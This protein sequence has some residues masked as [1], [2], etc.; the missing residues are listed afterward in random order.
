MWVESIKRDRVLHVVLSLEIGGAERIVSS[1]VEGG[2]ASGITHGVCCLDQ[3]GPLA[4]A[5]EGTGHDVHLVRRKPGIDLFMPFKLAKL[6]ALGGYTRLHAHGETPWF[7]GVLAVVLTL[8]IKFRCL[9]TIHGYGGGNKAALAHSLLWRLLMF[10]SMR[11]VVVSEDLEHEMKAIY[12]VLGKKVETIRNGISQHTR[13]SPQSRDDWGLRGKCVVGVVSRLAPVKNHLLLLKAAER[14]IGNRMSDLHVMI[15][16]DGP[17]REALEVYAQRPGLKGHVI[18]TGER[19]DALSFYSLFDLF[20]LPSLS[21]GLS[22]ALLE[23]A[24]FGIPLI[25]SSVGGNTEIVSHLET[26]LTFE[27]DNLDDLSRQVELLL[28]TPSLAGQLSTASKARVQKTFSVRFMVDS[29][30]RLYQGMVSC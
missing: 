15:V 20:V 11:V 4:E 24:T 19:I 3:K 27:S 28:D 12:P 5:L 23:A 1:L 17:E 26:G 13:V 30:N 29:Y 6:A 16:G 2:D 8:G 18:F 22:V 14:L 25:A 21:E 9:A 10:F 7:Y